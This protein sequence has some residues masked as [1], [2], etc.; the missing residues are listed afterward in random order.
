MCANAGS[1]G[2]HCLHIS[3]LSVFPTCKEGIGNSRIG[4]PPE[5][6]SI[7]SQRR[8]FSS[9]REGA[10]TGQVV[11][12]GLEALGETVHHLGDHLCALLRI[13]LGR[14]GH[15]GSHWARGHAGRPRGDLREITPRFFFEG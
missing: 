8:R 4:K 2:H 15:V 14:S 1:G 7:S 12:V 10:P 5:E 13:K 9:K 3:T 6:A 11:A